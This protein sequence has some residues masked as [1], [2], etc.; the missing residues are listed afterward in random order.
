MSQSV[1]TYEQREVDTIDYYF[2]FYNLLRP[3]LRGSDTIDAVDVTVLP[4]DELTVIDVTY[5]ATVVRAFAK[6]GVVGKTYT[7]SC[8][9][10]S[11]EG[12]E[13]TLDIKIT[14]TA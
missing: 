12:R 3:N 10:V 8:K 1:P 6:E 4:A 11:K 5:D 13:K 7:V 2:D 9:I 14:V